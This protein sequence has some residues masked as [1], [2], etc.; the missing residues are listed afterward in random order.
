MFKCNLELLNVCNWVRCLLLNR[1]VIVSYMRIHSILVVC[2]ISFVC[3]TYHNE[4]S[5]DFQI[6]NYSCSEMCIV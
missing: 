1:V 5:T 2:L 6:N 3:S 4:N